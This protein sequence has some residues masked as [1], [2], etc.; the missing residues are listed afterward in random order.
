MDTFAQQSFNALKS[1]ISTTPLISPPTYDHDYILYILASH[2]A[3]VGVLVQ[4]DDD[5]QEHIVYYISK[6][7]SR[8]AL[9]YSHAEKLALAVV[10]SVQKL[11][12]CILLRK[13][14][15]VSNSNPMQ[16]ILGCPIINGKYTLWIIILQ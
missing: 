1:V 10:H 5:R 16:Y 2:C 6:Q 15:V 14:I 11:H 12:H 3:V 13:N 9:K 8:P 7:L 4:Y